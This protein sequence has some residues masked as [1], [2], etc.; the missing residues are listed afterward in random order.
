VRPGGVLVADDVHENA[1][2]ALIPAGRR[3]IGQESTKAG[4]FGVAFKP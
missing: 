2:F 4:L 3:L 1:A